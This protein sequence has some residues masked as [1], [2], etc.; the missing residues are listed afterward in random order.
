MFNRSRQWINQTVLKTSKNVRN[1]N[2]C[3]GMPNNCLFLVVWFRSLCLILLKVLGGPQGHPKDFDIMET[4]WHVF[5]RVD[6]TRHRKSR[7]QYFCC[8][9]VV[10]HYMLVSG[11]N[12]QKRYNMHIYIA[13]SCILWPCMAIFSQYYCNIMLLDRLIYRF[14]N[15]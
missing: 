1:A 14:I 10:G 6:L 7:F 11:L 13:I 4:S 8:N 3:M 9:M 5:S 12:W 2:T 15:N